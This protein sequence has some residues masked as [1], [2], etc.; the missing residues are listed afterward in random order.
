M[1][2]ATRRAARTLGQSGVAAYQDGNYGGATEKLDKAYRAL[3]APSLGLWSARALVKVNRLIEAAERYQEVLRLEVSS[4][5]PAV[6]RQ[7]KADAASELSQL[8]PKIPN[9]VVNIA[10]ADASAVTVTID[11][12][13]VAAALIGENRP[14]DPGKHKVRGTIPGQT[15]DAELELALGETKSVTLTFQAA[16]VVPSGPRAPRVP[17]STPEAPPAD[18][19]KPG[20]VQHTAGIVAI[21]VGGAGLVFGGIAVALAAGK[22]STL[23]S[24][25][26]CQDNR[27]LRSEQATVDSYS[28]WRTVSTIGLLGG[29]ALAATGVVLVLSA[30]S[31]KTQL[32]LQVGPAAVA[33]TR[34]F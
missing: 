25:G 32:A 14:I 33:L 10:G 8:S 27:C 26:Q 31:Q 5:D 21:G 23:N 2:D 22:R 24:S 34:T 16:A 9:V 4:G 11:G 20:S 3:K 28:M 17:V 18:V 29:A 7:A 15:Q 30:P 1:D 19:S 12:V 6:Q 13:A